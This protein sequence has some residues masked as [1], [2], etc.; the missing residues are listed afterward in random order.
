[1]QAATRWAIVSCTGGAASAAP[2]ASQV[3]RV[4]EATKAA[5]VIE[6]TAPSTPAVRET[7]AVRARPGGRLVDVHC[8]CLAGARDM[9]GYYACRTEAAEP[10]DRD[11]VGARTRSAPSR[12]GDLDEGI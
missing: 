12:Q 9:T 8:R 10:T 5:K 11:R 7:E 6:A 4:I 2:P 1:M 3:A